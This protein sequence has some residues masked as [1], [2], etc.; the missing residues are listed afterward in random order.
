MPDPSNIRIR[1]TVSSKIRI[2]RRCT[3]LRKSTGSAS[4]PNPRGRIGVYWFKPSHCTERDLLAR[5]PRNYPE[6]EDQTTPPPRTSPGIPKTPAGSDAPLPFLAAASAVAAAGFETLETR[7][8]GLDESGE[9]GSNRGE[10][11]SGSL[12]FFFHFPSLCCCW[13]RWGDFLSTRREGELGQSN[14]KI[15]L[16]ALRCA[17]RSRWK[18]LCVGSQRDRTL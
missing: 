2:L 12:S 13:G 5:N 16:D 9:A 17:W 8:I 14:W 15:L 1:S 18:N 6:A 4:K 3:E 11:R 7:D 10:N